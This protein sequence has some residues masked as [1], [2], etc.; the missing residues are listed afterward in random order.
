MTGPL[1][2]PNIERGFTWTEEW[3]QECEARAVLKR[4]TQEARRA[5]LD[6]IEKVRGKAARASL[7]AAILR[8]WERRQRGGPPSSP[9]TSERRPDGR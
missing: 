1:T 8:E 6:E 3:R 4:P 7:E 9:S 2:Q 5:W